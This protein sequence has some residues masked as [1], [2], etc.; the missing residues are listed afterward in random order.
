LQNVTP[1]EFRRIVLHEFGHALGFIHEHQSPA[2]AIQWDK[3]KVYSFFGEAPMSMSRVDVDVN[4]FNKYA[5]TNT[6]FSSYDRFSIMHYSIPPEL[7]LDGM[8]SPRNSEFSYTDIEYAGKIYPFPINTPPA[9]GTLRTGDDCDLVDFKVEY[10]VLP[11]DQIE[12][13]LELGDMNGKAVTWW[14]KIEVPL[15]NNRTSGLWVQ[16]H[17]LIPSENRKNFSVQL[18]FADLNTQAPIAFWKAKILGVHTKL[19]F[20]W[21]V[22]RALKGGCR[23]RLIWKDDSCS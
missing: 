18:P 16:N 13:V 19:N 22:L 14:K 1:S 3:E 21:D 4:I 12:F 15:T 7:T 23:V 6:N 10:N 8:S 9:G 2:V 11:A 17:S 20:T 5:A